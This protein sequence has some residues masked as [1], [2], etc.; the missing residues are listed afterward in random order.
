MLKKRFRILVTFV[1]VVMSNNKEKKQPLYLPYL[2]LRKRKTNPLSLMYT[3]HSSLQKNE[4]L[5]P[6]PIIILIPFPHFRDVE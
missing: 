6:F 3:L 5:L 4:I 1:V 2:Y